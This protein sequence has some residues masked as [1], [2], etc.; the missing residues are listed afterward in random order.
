MIGLLAEPSSSV[1]LWE[2]AHEGKGPTHIWFSPAVFRGGDRGLKME[3][4]WGEDLGSRLQTPSPGSLYSA[5]PD[6]YGDCLFTGW[7]GR[8]GEPGARPVPFPRTCLRQEVESEPEL[9]SLD[10]AGRSPGKSWS[11][12][13]C[14]V[15]PRRP[16]LMWGSEALIRCLCGVGCSDATQTFAFVSGRQKEPQRGGFHLCNL[17]I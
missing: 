16:S 12:I 15:K 10:L 6:V 14:P 7:R 3:R 13:S 9:R 2:K 8:G 17:V 5:L 11:H 4:K 1:F